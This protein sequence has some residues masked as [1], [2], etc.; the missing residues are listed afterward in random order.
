MNTPSVGAAKPG[1]GR[2]LTFALNASATLKAPPYGHKNPPV[3]AVTTKQNPSTVHQG[4]LLYN[5]QCFFCHGL[6]A[7]AGPIPDLR[8]STKATLDAL[9][10]I[11]LRG[12][13]ASDGM[14]SFGKILTPKQVEAIRAY[15]IARAQESAKAAQA[16]Q[17]R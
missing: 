16:P 12:L 14:P 7:V 13:R 4:S 11:L 15:I 3:P 2:I 8:Y 10:D 6:N 5:S 17:R 1:W 9:P